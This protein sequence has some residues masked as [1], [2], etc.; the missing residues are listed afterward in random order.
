MAVS[1]LVM[2]LFVIAHLLGNTTIF[3]GSDSLNS[4]AE[5]LHDLALLIWT[6]RPIMIAAVFLHVFFGIQLTAENY[7]AKPDSYAIRKSLNSTF[8]GR[9]MIWTGVLLG[10]FIIYHLLQFTFQVTDP[11]ISADRNFDVFGRP[12]VFHMVVR[13]FR[14]SAV[15]LVYIGSMIALAF[16]L[17]HGI[18][19]FIQTL[20][21]NN[22]KTLPFFQKYG[23]LVAVI[24][25]AG[26]ISIPVVILAG[27]LKG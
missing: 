11:A 19:S 16:H 12:D 8:A 9:S 17:S 6:Y 20:G 26:F 24:I 25:S 1:G 2:L 22:E 18:Q 10:V 14:R 27:I 5:K 15:A 7:K 13:T 4:Y 3:A 23:T 21:L